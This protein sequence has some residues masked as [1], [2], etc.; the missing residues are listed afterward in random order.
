MFSR[1]W[2]PA[3]IVP[4]KPAEKRTL[5]RRVTIDLTGLPPTPAEVDDFVNDNSA[6][7]F[8]KVVDRL[9]DSPRYGE[10]WGRYWLDLWRYA[11][12]KGYVFN[13][14]RNYPFAHVYRD[15]VI[16]ALNEDLPYDQF[17]IQQLAA[18][19]SP[20]NGEQN[21]HLPAMG[22]LTLGRRFLNNK[23]DIIDDRIDVTDAHDDGADRQLCAAVTTISLIRSRRPTI[24]RFSVSLMRRLRSFSRWRRLP[25]TISTEFASARTRSSNS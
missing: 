21:S 24:T 3:G 13:E 7:A 11:D 10:R 12:T 18:D 25:K 15:W 8:E 5:I 16:R 22:F 14:D 17:L 4:G 19:R 1:D 6:D 20:Q 2:K 9:L 23:F